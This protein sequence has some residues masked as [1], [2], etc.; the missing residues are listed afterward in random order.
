MS[1][2]RQQVVRLLLWEAAHRHRF[3]FGEFIFLQ[4]SRLNRLLQICGRLDFEID[5]FFC[6]FVWP[7][8]ARVRLLDYLVEPLK[9]VQ[10]FLVVL[11]GDLRNLS[12]DMCTSK[13]WSMLL[14][15]IPTIS[16]LRFCSFS[17][18]SL[19]SWLIL[20]TPNFPSVMMLSKKQKCTPLDSSSRL[21]SRTC[22][23]LR[24][25]WSSFWWFRWASWWGRSWKVALPLK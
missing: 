6:W 15:P 3:R 23:K 22:L 10:D 8:T 19:A 12:R 20:A 11:A 5:H 1:R 24:L 9:H 25:H 7:R 14:L 13:F 21:L 16:N 17:C 4:L 2:K 18:S